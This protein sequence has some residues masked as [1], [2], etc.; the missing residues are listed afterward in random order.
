VATLTA[1]T[2]SPQ[3]SVDQVKAKAS[4]DLHATT[5]TDTWIYMAQYPGA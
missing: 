1:A 4:L 3:V 2:A 5:P